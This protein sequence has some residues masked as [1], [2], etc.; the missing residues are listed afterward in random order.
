MFDSQEYPAS[1]SENRFEQWLE[2]GR[3]SKMSYEYLLIVWDELDGKYRP[4]YVQKRSQIA[5]YPRW[6]NA[7]GH[8]SVIA[9]YDLYSEARISQG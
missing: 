7:S 5:Q 4:E 3:E 1:L 6:G 9:V 8:A 2:E